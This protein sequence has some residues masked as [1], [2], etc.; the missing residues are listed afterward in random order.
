MSVNHIGWWSPRSVLFW[1]G[2]LPEFSPDSAG[3]SR[4][5]RSTQRK[6]SRRRG[7]EGGQGCPLGVFHRILWPR[8]EGARKRGMVLSRVLASH[9][10]AGLA[11]EKGTL[12]WQQGGRPSLLLF[13]PL[14]VCV[15]V[16]RGGFL[17]LLTINMNA[18]NC[19]GSQHTGN[20][21]CSWAIFWLLY[22]NVTFVRRYSCV[23]EI[24]MKQTAGQC[25]HSSFKLPSVDEARANLSTGVIFHAGFVVNFISTWFLVQ[26]WPP[27]KL[28]KVAK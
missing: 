2:I 19:H 9:G 24:S 3:G 4:Q 23:F 21:R 8:S 10:R 27:S 11:G 26:S 25:I 15:C 1:D 22:V 7:G 14:I 5:P 18:L 28:M 17:R 6:A 16:W 13:T 20:V 12:G